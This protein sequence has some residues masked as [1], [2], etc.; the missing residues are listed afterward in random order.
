VEER[1]RER[2]AARRAQ[3]EAGSHVGRVGH[4]GAVLGVGAHGGDAA[5]VQHPQ[6][7]VG[8]Q[9]L[10][11]LRALLQDEHGLLPSLG[12]GEP[13]AEEAPGDL[14]LGEHLGWAEC[15]QEIAHVVRLLRVQEIFAVDSHPLL[16]GVLGVLAEEAPLQA[17]HA[18]CQGS[19]LAAGAFDP[20]LVG[21]LRQ[22]L[23]FLGLQV[24]AGEHAEGPL[25]GQLGGLR[26]VL[27]V[28]AA[29]QEDATVQVG[30]QF[31]AG[32]QV[33]AFGG[34]ALHGGAACHALHECLGS[35]VH[36]GLP[37]HLEVGLRRHAQRGVE[38]GH[39]R[40]QARAQPFQHARTLGGH[41]LRT[42]LCRLA[43]EA[44]V[45]LLQ[46]E[47]LLQEGGQLPLGDAES[48]EA[49]AGDLCLFQMHPL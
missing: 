33:L 12:G 4:R 25:G 42:S 22:G 31:G 49:G 32:H 38:A 20:A 41:R 44:H 8:E 36:H 34:V 14:H 3:G 46:G 16:A 47:P 29:R 28:F 19:A 48:V 26:G 39:L 27:L 18:L 17:A 6:E 15:Q 43:Q 23:L 40:P 10:P 45:E 24:A 5:R 9:L 37:Q 13:L 21:P 11:H 7:V 30:A 35:A 2:F 1:L